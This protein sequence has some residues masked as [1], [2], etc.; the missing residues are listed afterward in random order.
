MTIIE[1][2]S[3]EAEQPGE[4]LIPSKEHLEKL[5]ATEKGIINEQLRG[6]K[7]ILFSRLPVRHK[8]GRKSLFTYF[9]LFTFEHLSISLLYPLCKY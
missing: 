3:Q 7:S 2:L 6:N 9:S 8:H 1:T 5:T 4:R